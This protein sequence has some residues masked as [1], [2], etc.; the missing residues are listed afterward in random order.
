MHDAHH[1]LTTGNFSSSFTWWDHWMGTFVVDP[2]ACVAPAASG[3]QL[4]TN[5][6]VAMRPVKTV[7]QASAVVA[8]K[9]SKD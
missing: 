8:A 4:L 6:T 5:S 9:E 7:A 2:T 3:K 1:K